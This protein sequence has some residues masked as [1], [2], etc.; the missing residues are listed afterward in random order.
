[1]C[2]SL[3]IL[4]DDAHTHA[5]FEMF[6][7]K[8]FFKSNAMRSSKKRMEPRV[9]VTT[10]LLCN[11]HTFCIGMRERN[12]ETHQKNESN[13]THTTGFV[14]VFFFLQDS[15]G[16]WLISS[17]I[18]HFFRFD[19][20]KKRTKK[21]K[22]GANSSH[23]ELIIHRQTEKKKGDLIDIQTNT[24]QNIPHFHT[25]TH[26][27]H[28]LFFSSDVKKSQERN[29]LGEKSIE[30]YY[31]QNTHTFSVIRVKKRKK[32]KEKQVLKM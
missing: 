4:I 16:R 15:G 14:V 18:P 8:V 28:S 31:H 12:D 32:K 19:R 20:C 27:T 29:T 13:S 30:N 3:Y 7:L 17:K 26:T 11:T 24:T 23:N 1:M 5:I 10:T 25:H 6:L 22:K 21:Q 2:L 9:K